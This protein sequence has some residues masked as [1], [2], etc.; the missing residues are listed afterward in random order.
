MQNIMKA[1]NKRNKE[2][3]SAT[4]I[5]QNTI[6]RF[7][8]LRKPSNTCLRF[9][10]IVF[11]FPF[12]LLYIRCF[13]IWNHHAT[14]NSS[15]LTSRDPFSLSA[16]PLSEK[17]RGQRIDSNK[18]KTPKIL[19]LFAFPHLHST[20]ARGKISMKTKQSLISPDV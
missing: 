19:P 1:L 11:F 8:R 4:Q 18:V 10:Q 5:D 3:D 9:R 7:A 15:F 17:K 20:P 12:Y 16:L 14:Y 2:Y 13:F 6:L